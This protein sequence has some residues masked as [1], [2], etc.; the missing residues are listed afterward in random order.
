MDKKMTKFISTYP[1]QVK[2]QIKRG[3]AQPTKQHQ[4]L[5]QLPE[6]QHG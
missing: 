3:T 2:S 5:K 1:I 6:T 4:Q